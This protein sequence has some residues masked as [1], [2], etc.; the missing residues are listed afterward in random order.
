MEDIQDSDQ[1]TFWKV[2]TWKIEK[3][4]RG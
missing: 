1:E 4:M 2:S 3:E